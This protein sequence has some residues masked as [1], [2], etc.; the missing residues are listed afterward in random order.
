LPHIQEK[1]GQK[2]EYDLIRGVVEG[3]LLTNYRFTELKHDQLKFS[4][5]SLVQKLTLIGASKADLAKVKDCLAVSEA[6]NI[7]RNLVNGNADDITPQ[8]LA[9]FAKD[10]A[11]ELPKMTCHVLE[12]KE[13]V[14]EKMGLLLAVGRGSSIDPA[15]ITLAYKGNAKSKEHIVIVG[16]GV[17]YDTGG[18]HLKPF[19]AM[20]SMKCDM[21]GGAVALATAYASAVLGLKINVTAVVPATENS[22]DANSFKPG[23]VYSSYSGKTVEIGNTDAEGRLILADAISYSLKHLKPSCLIDIATLTGAIDI[24]LG[25]EACGLFA[26]NNQLAEA[27]SAAGNDSFERVW[28]LPL[29]EEYRDLLKSDVADIRNIGGRSAGCIT[30]AIFLQEFVGRGPKAL[31]WAHLDIASTAYLSEPRRYHPKS[32]TGFGVRLLISFLKAF[33]DGFIKL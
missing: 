10:I 17:T 21:A 30:S 29:H 8:Y 20:E 14:K 7:A 6:V 18:L 4:K 2:L 23:D 25:A 22:I 13:L 32:G 5:P 27:L 31:P 28:Q 1:E 3:V 33:E 19:G 9:D 26:N 12:K 11:K 15:L 16:K 24:A